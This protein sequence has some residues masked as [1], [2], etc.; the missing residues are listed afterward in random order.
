M[1]RPLPPGRGDF[2][3]MIYFFIVSS[4]VVPPVG[5]LLELLACQ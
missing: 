3:P 2:L 5:T 4:F 1:E